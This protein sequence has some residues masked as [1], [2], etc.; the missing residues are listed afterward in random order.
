MSFKTQVE[1]IVGVSITD[2]S[3]IADF[4]TASAREVADILPSRALMLNALV[5]ED[6]TD[7]NGYTASNQKIFNVSRN[8]KISVEVPYGLSTQI[9]VNSGSIHE[10]TV[11][12]PFHYY[13]GKYLYIHPAPTSS[14][15]GEIFSFAYPIVAVSG[16]T[17]NLDSTSIPSFPSNAE[18]AVILG[19]AC[20]YFTKMISDEIEASPSVVSINDLSVS[21]VS[22]TAPSLGTSSVTLAGSAPNYTKPSV[23]IS[24]SPVIGALN[25]TDSV[26]TAPILSNSSI[27]FD[28]T[29]PDYSK[30]TQVFDIAPFETFLQTDEDGE[31][32]QIQLG[33]L[34]QQLGEFQANIQNELNN[35][36]ESNTV[37]QAELQKSIETSR[38]T[39]QDDAKKIQKYSSEVSAYQASVGKQVQQYKENTQR[40]I[41]L[42]Q[43]KRQTELQ[44]YQTDIQNE[45]NEF[46]KENVAYQ[47]LTQKAM[48]DARLS[49]QD[50]AQK[51]QK[52]GQEVSEYGAT[53]N[54]EVQE[55]QA[56]LAQK[57][58]ELGANLQRTQFKTQA[59]QQQYQQCEAKYQAE[60]ARLSGGKK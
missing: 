57:T 1:D 27:T 44:K 35:F 33:R 60:K 13:K 42:W 55:Y 47:V 29:A 19:G 48:E 28:S 4:L 45:L 5:N 46:N 40:D 34:Q 26:P 20:K 37:Y 7:G 56:N 52:Y 53:L 8:G 49:S 38:L 9:A 3:A 14:E 50:D 21:A 17:L 10:S 12:T 18:F 22:P 36:N 23:A 58:Q 6:T 39:S 31:L 24:D 16:G 51:I 15:K 30:P 32:A 41:G 11:R 43:T 59:L 2:T 54:K 25:I